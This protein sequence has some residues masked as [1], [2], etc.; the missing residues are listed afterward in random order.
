[1][2][3]SRPVFTFYSLATV[4]LG[5]SPRDLSAGYLLGSRADL[6]VVTKTK[7]TLPAENPASDIITI[8]TEIQ[9]LE[10]FKSIFF[11]KSQYYGSMILW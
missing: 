9:L 5:K 2:L 8:L 4:F 6:G 3:S 7:I 1:V 11:C 10:H